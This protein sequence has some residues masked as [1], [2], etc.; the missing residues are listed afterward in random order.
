MGFLSLLWR[1]RVTL[2]ISAVLAAVVGLFFGLTGPITFTSTG[3]LLLPATDPVA[4]GGGGNAGKPDASLV[5]IQVK[6]YSDKDLSGEVRRA[7]GQDAPLL[8]SIRAVR[9]RDPVFYRLTAEAKRGPVARAAIQHASDAMITKASDLA[10]SQVEKLQKL[11]T[12]RLGPLD[13]QSVTA[14]GEVITKQT[15]Y[16]SLA[17]QAKSLQGQIDAARE[18]AA[19]AAV[20]GKGSS[21]TGSAI[22]GSVQSQ[23]DNLNKQLIPAQVAYEQ[24]KSK[25]AVINAQRQGLQDQVQ[26]ATDSYLATQVSASLAAPPTRPISGRKLK[27]ATMVALEILVS[28]AVAAASI[29]WLER[30]QVASGLRGRLRRNRGRGTVRGLGAPAPAQMARSRR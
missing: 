21:S 14:A 25:A 5:G 30:R 26:K 4:A 20:S 10:K 18:A 3:Q 22:A 9:L 28:L 29:A 24:A 8:N 27:L 17:A 19:R 12:E 13:Q 7:L 6:T 1:H 16:E 15:A 2:V 23:L 11:V